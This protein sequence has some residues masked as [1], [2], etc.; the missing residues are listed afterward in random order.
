M[1]ETLLQ[2]PGYFESFFLKPKKIDVYI[3]CVV[4]WRDRISGHSY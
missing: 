2:L 3:R 1:N 4:N